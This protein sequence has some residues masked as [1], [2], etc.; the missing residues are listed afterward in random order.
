MH[1]K[2]RARFTGA[3][4]V[5]PATGNVPNAKWVESPCFK[6]P[7]TRKNKNVSCVD[8]EHKIHYN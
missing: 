7:V 3:V 8:L 6:D 4:D 1:T 5:T 2:K